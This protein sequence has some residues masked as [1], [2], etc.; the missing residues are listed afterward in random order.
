MLQF[1][2]VGS[3]NKSF[4]FTAST[5]EGCK[6]SQDGNIQ[7]K[8]DSLDNIL[9]NKN[10]TFIKMDID[11]A[12]LKSLE[13]AQ[14]IIKRCYL[15]LAI[16]IYHSDGGMIDI[17]EHILQN[18]PQYSIYIRHYTFSMQILYCMLPVNNNMTDFRN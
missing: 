7:I 1:R 13:G 15:K 11:G 16:S 10:V 12:E 2:N 5:E 8:V 14:E 17:A 3:K 4:I 18:Y 6:I 9:V